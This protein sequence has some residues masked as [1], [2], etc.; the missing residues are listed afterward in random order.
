MLK[1]PKVAEVKMPYTSRAASFA[2]DSGGSTPSLFNSATKVTRPIIG[3]QAS[4]TGR[5][6]LL[7]GV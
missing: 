3:G 1:T 4:N 7:G 5:P 2:S 6:S